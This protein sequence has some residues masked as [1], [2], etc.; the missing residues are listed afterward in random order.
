MTDLFRGALYVKKTDAGWAPMRF[1]D[2][3][4]AVWTSHREGWRIRSQATSAISLAFAT[5]A[6]VI[7]M[8]FTAVGFSRPFLGFDV[9]EN[10]VL[11]AHILYPDN[12]P[13]GTLEYKCRAQGE[14]TVEIYLSCLCQIIVGGLE[15][16]NVRPLPQPAHRTLFIGDSITQGMT[17]RCPSL[18]YPVLYCRKKGQQ[19]IDLGVGGGMFE[20]WQ[21]DYLP[22]FHPSDIF[23]AYGINDLAHGEPNDVLLPRAEEFLEKL[24]G[25]HPDVPAA[26]ITPLW[27]KMMEDRPGFP[28]VYAEYCTALAGIAR[29]YGYRVVDGERLLPFDRR[30]TVDGTHPN[31][32]GSALIALGLL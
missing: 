20:S 16:G 14:K 13:E 3:A 29:K 10:G 2:E 25:I 8:P 26:V 32:E 30:H 1:T 18:I 5:D 17:V 15:A 6:D 11:T 27:N 23:V 4:I 22:D 28:A 31:E 21:L 24:R 7:R 12:T 9:Y 19:P